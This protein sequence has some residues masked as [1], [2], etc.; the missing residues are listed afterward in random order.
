MMFFTCKKLAAIFSYLMEN[1]TLKLAFLWIDNSLVTIPLI[2]Y[3][4]NENEIKLKE[5]G[6]QV[7]IQLKFK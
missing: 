1:K 6:D 4:I 3:Q 5:Y 7:Q 2:I